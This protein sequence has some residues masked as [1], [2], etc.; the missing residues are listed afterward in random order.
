MK[1][2]IVSK[3]KAECIAVLKESQRTREPILITRRGQPLARIE[4]IV[5]SP[6][7]RKFNT[8]REKAEIR[9]DLVHAPFDEE[10]NDRLL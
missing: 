1:K 2:M 7:P 5:S 4:P 3:F 9:G 8:L 6:P 10:W